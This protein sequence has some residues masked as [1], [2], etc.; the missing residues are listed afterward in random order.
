MA[1]TEQKISEL[2]SG[3]TGELNSE[4]NFA[5]DTGKE[6]TTKKF[7]F[8]Q[9]VK[10]AMTN[11]PLSEILPST[12][13]SSNKLATDFDINNTRGDKLFATASGGNFATYVQLVSG[14]WYTGDGVEVDAPKPYQFAIIDN[15]VLHGGNRAR[16]YF[17][18]TTWVFDDVEQVNLTPE[19]QAAL[20][21][22]VTYE[23]V[24][25][26]PPDGGVAANNSQSLTKAVSSDT[27]A[28]SVPATGIRTLLQQIWNK[29]Q[30]IRDNFARQLQSYNNVTAD[31][32]DAA[33]VE[34]TA[35]N[36]IL[37][38][39][40]RK[41]NGIRAGYARLDGATF[42]GAVELPGYA[43]EGM[44][45]VPLAQVT[46][47]FD[48]TASEIQELTEA[49]P[50][51]TDAG[52]VPSSPLEQILQKIWNKIQGVRDGFARIE[53]NL[54]NVVPDDS[55]VERITNTPIPTIFSV[56]GQKINGI[57]GAYARKDGATFTGAVALGSDAE[58]DMEA[59]TLRQMN[60]AI[61]EGFDTDQN[62]AK[63]VPD[64][65]NAN[66]TGKV[67]LGDLLQAIWNKI[68]GIRDNFARKLQS[69]NNVTADDSNAAAVNDIDT[70]MIFQTHAKKINGIRG[71]YARLDGAQFSGDIIL[72]GDAAQDLNPV[73]LQQL[74]AGLDLKVDLAQ[75][76]EEAAP[77]DTD[78]EEIKSLTAL[79]LWQAIWNKIQGIRD[80]YARKLQSFSDVAADDTAIAAVSG[81]DTETI[82]SMLAKKINGIRGAYARKDGATFTGSVVLADNATDDMEAVPLQQV[83][84]SR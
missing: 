58:E 71:N 68:Q 51:D 83:D 54:P 69:Y 10:Q 84:D 19:Q 21:S 76:I 75:S 65:T 47:L 81:K 38:D 57:R 80:N 7:T 45:P 78:T 1:D 8:T 37:Q 67:H 50:D 14:A 40:A 33:P 79:E 63:A 77:D 41:I 73:P 52:E 66:A 35:L 46:E 2:T 32:S 25:Q 59:V 44:E 24:E 12:A 43:S 56:L 72:P 20:D 3:E 62:L 36:V 61:G 16:Y 6:G 42:T 22:G 26:L 48:D 27:D 64:D 13:S 23:K 55:A 29:I 74:N 30:G 70:E 53:Q 15:D 5:A 28:G 4:A 39:N 60:T 31:D 34:D 9:I 49:V 82:F 11:S 17:S 18:N